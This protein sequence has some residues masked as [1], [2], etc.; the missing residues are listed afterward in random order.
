MTRKQ[1]EKKAIREAERRIGAPAGW[2]GTWRHL[3]GPGGIVV[4]ALP[5]GVWSI[6]Q[7]GVLVSKHDSRA[8]ALR[9]AVRLAKA[10]TS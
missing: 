10:R 2:W 5:G 6:Q 8:Y 4:R 7:D 1:F 9:K 3:H